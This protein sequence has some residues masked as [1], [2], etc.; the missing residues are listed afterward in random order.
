METLDSGRTNTPKSRITCEEVVRS[1]GDKKEI[2]FNIIEMRLYSN[3][4][5]G[6]LPRAMFGRMPHLTTVVLFDNNLKGEN[7]VATIP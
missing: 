6:A 7:I 4:L 2:Q 1:V 3:N 5:K